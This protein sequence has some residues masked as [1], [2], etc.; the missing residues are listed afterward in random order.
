[1]AKR[2]R[3]ASHDPDRIMALQRAAGVPAVVAQ[4]LICRGIV[5]AGPA[6]EFLDP[7]L[8]GLRDPELLPGARQAAQQLASAVA[9]GRRIVVYG[10]Y[11]ADGMTGTSILLLAS[12]SLAQMPAPTCPIEWTKATACTTTHCGNWPP[13]ARS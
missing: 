4:L 6:R 12:D 3:I 5:D 7:K 2:W 13:R 11:D 1:M 9:E 10:D 8:S